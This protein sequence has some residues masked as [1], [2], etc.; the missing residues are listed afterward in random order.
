MA[1]LSCDYA[2]CMVPPE[3]HEICAAKGL[4]PACWG[5]LGHQHTPKRSRGGKACWVNLCE[6]HADMIDNGVRTAGVRLEDEVLQHIEAD[7]PYVYI[8]RD[9]DTNEIVKV[10]PL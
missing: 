1:D 10:I 4:G 7:E 5:V 8:I 3:R 6:G 9:R 2:Q